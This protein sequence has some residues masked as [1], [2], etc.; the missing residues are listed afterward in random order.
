MKLMEFRS[1]DMSVYLIGNLLNWNSTRTRARARARACVC[2][3]V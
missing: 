2:V 3:C 1:L